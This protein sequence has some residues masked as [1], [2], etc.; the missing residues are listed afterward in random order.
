MM[1]KRLTV[2]K[3]TAVLTSP[4][5]IPPCARC[6][7]R[8]LLH[9]DGQANLGQS[10]APAVSMPSD[11][12]SAPSSSTAGRKRPREWSVEDVVAFLESCELGHVKDAFRDNGVDGGFLLCLSDDELMVD[13][14][15]TKLQVKKIRL[16][17]PQ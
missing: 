5:K 14:G 17:L 1:L 13:L 2:F 3:F 6:F 12:P 8:F 11:V 4:K 15:L 10:F 16:R 7:S 9:P